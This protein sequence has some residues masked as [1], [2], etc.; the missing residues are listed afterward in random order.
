MSSNKR[1]RIRRPG[2]I[3]TCK[4][5][6]WFTILQVE[7]LLLHNAEFGD[8]SDKQLIEATHEMGYLMGQY[9]KLVQVGD[10]EKRIEE[11]EKAL[12]NK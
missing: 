5:K 10:I 11:I 6:L 3:G 1:Q 4:K 9:A 2:S 8:L 12:E 7:D